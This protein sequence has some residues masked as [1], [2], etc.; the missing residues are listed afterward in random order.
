MGNL[1]LVQGARE[2]RHEF[3][4]QLTSRAHGMGRRTLLVAP[5]ERASHARLRAVLTAYGL[6]GRSVR[7]DGSLPEDSNPSVRDALE[8]AGALDLAVGGVDTD[9]A[10]LLRSLCRAPVGPLEMVTL[11]DVDAAPGQV[12]LLCEQLLVPSSLATTLPGRV[13]QLARQLGAVVVVTVD[14]RDDATI[15]EWGLAADQ[16]LLVTEEE[17]LSEEWHVVS[18]RIVEGTVRDSSTARPWWPPV[19]TDPRD[20]WHPENRRRRREARSDSPRP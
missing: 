6:R 12:N 13:H 1:V 19:E 10:A 14:T 4:F 2:D 16:W 20:V 3:A 18:R 15:E 8:V 9:P 7:V 5:F 11:L 17:E